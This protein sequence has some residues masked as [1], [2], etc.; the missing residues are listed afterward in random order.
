[1][2]KSDYE[3]AG[4]ATYREAAH[5][6]LTSQLHEMMDNLD[7]TRHGDVEALHDMRVASRRLRAAMSVF[8]AAFAEKRFRALEK[9][10]AGVTDALGAVRDADVL[11]EFLAKKRDAAS[12]AERIGINALME[13]V[14]KQR[15]HD[16]VH[17]VKAV[18]KIESGSFLKDFHQLV[19]T[20]EETAHG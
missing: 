7:G 17:L 9:Q 20:S 14:E 5:A 1:M 15:D 16:R 2:A 8:G 19:S 4:T 12:E 3:I 18:S 13:H 6:A 10:V 11:L